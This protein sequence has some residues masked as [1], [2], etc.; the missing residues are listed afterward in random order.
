MGYAYYKKQDYDT[1]ISHF[2]KIIDGNNAVAQNAYYHLAECYLKTGKKSEALNAFRNASQMTFKPNIQEDAYLNYAKLSYEIGNPYKS[3]PEVLQDFLQA[4]PNSPESESI[5]NLIVSAYVV[6]KDY[7]GALSY[8]ENTPNKDKALYQNVAY[9]RG[10]QL[11]AEGKNQAAKTHFEKA[12]SQPIDAKLTAKTNYWK[13][14]TSYQLQQYS[15][16]LQGYKAFKN[17]DEATSC[18]ENTMV[19]YQMGY[20]YFKQKKYPEAISSFTTYLDSNPTEPVKKNDAYLRLGDS[21]FITSTYQKAINA[22]SKSAQLNTKTADYALF[23]SALSYGF[24]KDKTKKI[25]LLNQVISGYRKSVYRDDA[26]YVLASTYTTSNNTTKALQKYEQLI[27]EHPKSSLVARAMLKK[28]LIYYNNNQNDKALAVYKKAVR[29]YPNTPIAQEAV[30]NARQIYVDTGRVDE[31]AVW[32]GD[33]DFINVTDAEL[34]H[35]MYE[36]AERQYTMN[37]Y[38]KA[39]KAFK[40]YLQNFPKGQH[41][42]HAHFYLAQAY[43]SQNQENKTLSHYKYVTDQQQNEFTEQALSRLSQLYLNQDKWDAAVPLLIRLEQMADHQQNILYAQSNLMKAYYKQENYSQAVVYADKVLAQSG[44]EIKVKSDATI[45]IA[46][47]AIKTQDEAKARTAYKEVENMASGELKAEA[48]Y[49]DAYFKHQDGDYNN[50][51]IVVQKIASDYA[52]YKYWGAKALIIMAKNFYALGDAYQ[53]TYIL[54]SVI[55]NF[56]Q[57]EDVVAEAQEELNSIKTNEA[58]TNDSVIPE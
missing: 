50:S 45:I 54:D 30:R 17:S 51:N 5:N 8:L 22:Y 47:S 55:K 12:L 32:V 21:Y 6:S 56:K 10:T 41:S 31:Y 36:S 20:V 15:E 24:V 35:D 52:A 2:N 42:L 53:A 48:L 28:G 43:E 44:V 29:L 26:L 4:Y 18:Y 46:R 1:A 16:A 11:F 19:A 33:L 58:K 49:Y 25:N 3:V 39:I 13:G 14:E 34:D 57:F 38:A 9:L 27:T 37:D 7:K 40:K 23:Q